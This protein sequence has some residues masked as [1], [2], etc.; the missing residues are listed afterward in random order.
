MTGTPRFDDPGLF[1]G[2]PGQR[3]AEEL[4]VVHVD[5]RDDS[6]R[7]AVDDVG[8][9]QPAAKADLEQ[10]VIGGRLGEGQKGGRGGDLEIGD[11]VGTVGLQT[12]V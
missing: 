7:R 5:G 6:Q 1:G 11:R 12:G 2:D 8:R 10:G 9:I 4:L 3:I